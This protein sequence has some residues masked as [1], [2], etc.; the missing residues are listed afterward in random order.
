MKVIL[1]TGATD[2]IG[3]EAAKV[4]AAKGHKLLFHG[5]SPQKLQAAQQ[6]LEQVCSADSAQPNVE[7]FVADFS[8]LS[9]VQAMAQQVLDK[10]DKID[11]L[12]N[13]AGV[14]KLPYENE[15]TVDGLDA[16]FAVN[17]LAPYLLTKRLLPII[18]K[19]GRVINISS[20]AQ[21]PVNLMS[22]RGSGGRMNAGQAYAQSKLAITTWSHYL[23]QQQQQKEQHITFVAVNPAS[24]IG[25]KM[26][27]E[28]YGVAGKSLSIGADI[29]TQAAV[30]SKFNGARVNGKY[31]N[32]DIGRFDDPH[33]DATNLVKGQE[34]VATMDEI[35]ASLGLA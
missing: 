11:V 8:K 26:V 6:A 22:L 21:T 3:L 17:T 24:L 10:H 2:G 9:D 23:S 20:A 27:R 15:R 29:L 18:S 19:H 12:L 31:F 7:T 32:N 1:L 28:G 30:G 14:F 13:N 16:R 25:T 5:R 4:L 35:L 33:P 34:L